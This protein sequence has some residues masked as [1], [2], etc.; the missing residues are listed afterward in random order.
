LETELFDEIKKAEPDIT[1]S[2]YYQDYGDAAAARSQNQMPLFL[3]FS[4][5]SKFADTLDSGVDTSRHTTD[6]YVDIQYSTP[7][8]AALANLAALSWL[9]CSG[10]IH[11]GVLGALELRR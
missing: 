9:N 4:S 11:I 6:A 1:Q 8:P 10:H 3:S 5:A 7:A 2:L